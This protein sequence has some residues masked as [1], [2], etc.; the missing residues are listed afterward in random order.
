MTLCAQCH[1]PTPLAAHCAV[2]GESPLLVEK[3]EL[4]RV[5]GEG[6]QGVSFLGQALG[7]DQPVAIKEFLL[8]RASSWKALEQVEREGAALANIKHPNVP[9][10][11]ETFSVESGRAVAFYVVRDYVEGEDLACLGQISVEHAF[12]LASSLLD[13]LADLHELPVP[14]VHRD[15]KPGNLILRPDGEVSIVD[16]GSVRNHQT[17]GST[18]A[19]TFGYMAPEQLAGR[20]LPASD[21]YGVGATI[22][23]LVSGRDPSELL[24]DLRRRA[25]NT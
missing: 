12:A 21:V 6:A 19:G 10:L 14:V 3:Y 24:A 17:Q 9:R 11:I 8:R 5:V 18:I 4:T 2:C 13:T 1:N 15:I 23:A 22:V 7:S 16:F 20:A 25:I